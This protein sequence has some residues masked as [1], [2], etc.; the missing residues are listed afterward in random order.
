[1]R[2]PLWLAAAIVLPAAA[3]LLLRSLSPS[4]PGTPPDDAGKRNVLL[5]TLDTT[6]ADHL[7]SYGATKA[8]TPNLD[9]LAR[10]GTLFTRCATCSPQTLPSHASI[11]T[12]V[13]PYVHGARRN[14]TTR[15][16]GTNLTLAESLQQAGYSTRAAVA[17]FVLDRRFGTA[18]GF[19]IYHGV[20]ADSPRGERRGDEVRE[21]SVGLLR[22]VAAEPFFLW[23]H[24]FDPHYPY[25]SPRPLAPHSPEAYQ[26]EIAFMDTQIGYLLEEISSLGLERRTLV[27]VVSDHGEGLGQHDEPTHKFFLYESTLHAPLIFWSPGT[28]PAGRRIEAQVRT[29]DVAPTILALLGLPGW[30]HAQGVSLLPLLN[31]G[32]PDPDLA[33][34]G[35]TIEPSILF[36]LSPL[37]SLS[38]GGWKYILAPRPE[39]FNL[40]TD[41]GET[42][43]L[44]AV[45]PDIAGRMRERLRTLIAAAPP[46]PAGKDVSVELDESDIARLRSLGY[47]ASGPSGIQPGSVESDWFEPRG[48]D[49]KDYI[50][51]FR[52]KARLEGAL[53]DED[54]ELAERLVRELVEALPEVPQLQVDSANVLLQQ[55]RVDEALE[56]I[57]AA[58][59]MAPDDGRPAAESIP[60]LLEIQLKLA[61]KLQEAGRLDEAEAVFE[62]ALVLAPRAVDAH[63]EYGTF[64][65]FGTHQYARAAEQLRIALQ[66]APDDV[67]VMHDLGGALTVLEQFERAD[68]VLARALD[69]E[70]K[71]PRILQAIGYLRLKQNRLPEA[72]EYF[73]KTL[74]VAP[75]TTQARDALEFVQ[76]KMRQ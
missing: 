72:A 20:K 69:L 19:D 76:E 9:R 55:G 59:V 21:D 2:T 73:R 50:G 68:Q 49:P 61:R 32:E 37:R 35:E 52:K 75:D 29:I 60:N 38:A 23:A 11:L 66:Q 53:L 62:R 12:A 26:D 24:F 15:M 63:R 28:I 57:D 74:E 10:E 31:G 43:N 14:G 45:Q 56:A 46:S 65:L 30:E 71:N 5:I 16:A 58:V 17:S 64:L 3:W 6:R 67:N 13:Y 54:F 22:S 40:E 7:G 4:S 1:L 51:H 8:I 39:L 70:P 33:A 25:E 27:V 36:G 42:R 44:I 34:Y 41:P 48:G 18:Q 47:T